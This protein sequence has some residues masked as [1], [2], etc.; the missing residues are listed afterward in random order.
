MN[1]T[2]SIII[3]ILNSRVTLELVLRCL[4]RQTVPLD[5]FECLVVDDGSTDGTAEFLAHYQPLYDLHCFINPTN[6]GR[7]T[8][9][10]TALRHARGE[11][12]LF[13]DGDMLPEPGWLAEYQL[14]FETTDFDVLSGGRYC[15][16]VGADWHRLADALAD[17]AGCSADALFDGDVAAQFRGLGRYATLGQYT[18]TTTTFELE[19]R[20]LCSRWPT[21]LISAYSVITSNVG[22]RRQ[23]LDQTTG[24]DPM[25]QRG[26]DTELGL[27]L[28]ELGARFGF[29]ERAVAYHLFDARQPR[30]RG[31][32]EHLAFFQRHPYRMVLLIYFCS[33]Y[34][35]AGATPPPFFESLVRLAEA[36]AE[37]QDVDVSSM[38]YRLHNRPLPVDCQ[39]D[40]ATLIDYYVECGAN[41][42]PAQIGSYLDLAV[43]RGLYVEKDGDRLLFD[44]YHT[45]NWLRKCTPLQE[46]EL[47]H[48]IYVYNHKTPFLRTGRADELLTMSYHGSYT[49]TVAPDVLHESGRAW[50]INIPLPIEHCCQSN[51]RITNC[52]PATLLDYV[53]PSKNMIVGFP[54]R[55][56]RGEALTVGYEFTCDVRECAPLE[57]D[58]RPATP[59]S[60]ARYL[61]PTYPPAQ[62]ELAKSA[63]KKIFLRP[64]D[65]SYTMARMIHAWVLDNLLFLQTSFPDW[66]ALQ[67]GAGPCIH[68]ARLFINLCRLMRI[69][70]R[71]QCG[72]L[73]LGA[74]DPHDERILRMKGWGFSQFAHTWAEFY[75]PAHGWIP[76]EFIGRGFGKRILT[77]VN[78]VDRQLR[79]ELIA[80]T[81]R[82]DAYYCGGIDPYRIYT[83]EHC[84]KLPTYP[85][86]AAQGGARSLHNIIRH[87]LHELTLDIAA[88]HGR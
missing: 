7:S 32:D 34:N 79:D 56:C 21:S 70:A 77:G 18:G 6:L 2:F 20:E 49:I 15:L 11:I 88:Q 25:V 50:T 74:L 16:N 4:E 28:W 65:D 58:A 31:L 10:N 36:G 57:T 54:L 14:A 67:L 37:L 42:T 46:H 12:V 53:D 63:L 19:L 60:L 78:V 44:L 38:F 3:P 71:E 59:A 29:A 83:S 33:L 76:A 39:Y 73:F 62:L 27:R 40:R 47:R 64:V 45:T 86:F 43:E 24:F 55:E 80:D 5:Q 35:S 69:P 72:A 52:T 82:F 68:Q 26:E 75:T 17:M 23:L 22:V 1:P 8:A 66:M 81:P 84:S 30:V 41:L 61:R 85:V 51:V 13:L 9:R 48:F 87:T